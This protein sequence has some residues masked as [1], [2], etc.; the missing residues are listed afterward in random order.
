MAPESH[1]SDGELLRHALN[2][3]SQWFT[4]WSV[5]PLKPRE[6][7]PLT[8]H[9]VKDATVD[10]RII[11]RWWSR[12]PDANIGIACG[13]P[14]SAGPLRLLVVDLDKPSSRVELEHHG[15]LPDTL[16][17]TTG[18]GEH[19]YF[20]AATAL[21]TTSLVAGV[22][23]RGDGG[24]VAAPPSLHPNGATYTW[25]DDEQSIAT[26]P[27][28]L[29]L[30]TKQRRAEHR[31]ELSNARTLLAAQGFEQGELDVLT[32]MIIEAPAGTRNVTA[33]T[34][35]QA[36]HSLIVRGIQRSDIYAALADACT[37]AGLEPEETRHALRSIA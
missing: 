19:H 36:A 22:D 11:R 1:P 32:R 29:V 7:I 12:W 37:T 18:R 5:H 2:Y 10:T 27:Q 23:T 28:W 13:A 33:Y 9:G 15:E 4:A 24:Y 6:K 20:Y 14:S 21:S 17:A 8:K 35:A 30:L 3:A 25:I 16:V 34:A 31:R 26:A